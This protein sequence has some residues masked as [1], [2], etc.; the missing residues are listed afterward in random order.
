MYEHGRDETG[1]A[2]PPRPLQTQRAPTSQPAAPEP[3]AVTPA[4]AHTP[5][6]A[7]SYQDFESESEDSQ[8]VLDTPGKFMQQLFQL[9]VIR[10]CEPNRNDMCAQDCMLHPV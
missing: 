6:F 4:A 7:P 1:R 8:S 9:Q 3:A 10:G 2:A 5:A